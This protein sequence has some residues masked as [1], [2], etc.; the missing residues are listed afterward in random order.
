[1]L[2]DSDLRAASRH[3]RTASDNAEGLE[4]SLFELVNASASCT[5]KMQVLAQVSCISF[6]GKN[7][8]RRK[9]CAREA[10]KGIFG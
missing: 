5:F 6:K 7:Y 2:L 10:S 4:G 8:S 3:L 9:A 1:M